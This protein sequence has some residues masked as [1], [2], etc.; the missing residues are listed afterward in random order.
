MAVLLDVIVG[1]DTEDTATARSK[2]HIA[3]SY[4]A[5]LK[6][7]GLKGARLG[8]LRQAF[9]PK[10]ADPLIIE[11][12]EKTIAEYD[13]RPEHIEYIS[14]YRKQEELR[15]KVAALINASAREVALLQNATMGSNLIAHG[16]DTVARITGPERLVI[17][18]GAGDGESK[19]ENESY[20]LG[21]G[22]VE[23]RLAM[24]RETVD[25]LRDRGYPVWIGG[26]DPAVR[27]MAAAHADG[28]NRWGGPLD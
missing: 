4:Q 3:Q 13:Y 26:T 1:P 17:A 16:L 27:E 22:S 19:E 18:V 10:V 23:D 15:A 9:N 12:F 7:D 5:F 21:F 28:W 11:H 2:G 8:V 24:L 6:K 20:G 25:T 14:G